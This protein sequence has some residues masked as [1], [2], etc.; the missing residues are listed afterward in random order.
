MSFDPALSKPPT[1]TEFGEATP[2]TCLRVV[3]AA[4]TLA[5]AAD[6]AA[7]DAFCRS[8]TRSMARLETVMHATHRE[9]VEAERYAALAEEWD[10]DPSMPDRALRRC[11]T[12]AV[13]HALAAQ[14]EAGVELTALALRGELE[15]ALTPRS[16]P[17]GRAPSASRRPRKRPQS[18]PPPAWT[19]RTGTSPP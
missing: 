19:R 2:Q 4:A 17:S 18:V 13:T 6:D 16:A 3:R 11:A 5:A 14:R 10:A 15:R 7:L 12:Q 9:A 1:P 8:S